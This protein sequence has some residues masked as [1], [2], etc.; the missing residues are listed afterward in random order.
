MKNIRRLALIFTVITA[1]RLTAGEAAAPDNSLTDA[2]KA[3]GWKLLFAGQSLAGWHN[4]K[5]EGMRAG[6]QVKDGARLC[7]SP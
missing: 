1:V 6:W 4:F 5:Q 7:R 3:A 2:E